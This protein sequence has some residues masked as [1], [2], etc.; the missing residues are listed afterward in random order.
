M[1]YRMDSPARNRSEAS[2][3]KFPGHPN[4]LNFTVTGEGPRDGWFFP[5]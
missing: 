5:A 1:V 3:Q 2:L 4:K